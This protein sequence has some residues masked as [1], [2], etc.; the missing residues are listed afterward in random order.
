MPLDGSARP[1]HRVMADL[2]Q[3]IVTGDVHH[4][5]LAPDQTPTA[6]CSST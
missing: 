3:A 5:I 6:T 2:E 1:H 4:V